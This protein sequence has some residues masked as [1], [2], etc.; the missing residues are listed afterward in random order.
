VTW[1]GAGALGDDL[2]SVLTG[3]EVYGREVIGA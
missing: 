2:R 3:I 1:I